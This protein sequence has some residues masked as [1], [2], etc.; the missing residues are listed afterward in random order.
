MVS[1]KVEEGFPVSANEN[2]FLRVNKIGLRIA[3][4]IKDLKYPYSFSVLKVEDAN[5]FALPGG[6][7]YVTTGLLELG[8]EDS[9]LAFVLA[10]EIAHNECDHIFKIK[11]KANLL[12]AIMM[13]IEI[14]AMSQTSSSKDARQ[15]QAEAAARSLAYSLSGAMVVSGYSREFEREADYWGK[16]YLAKAGYDI[17]GAKTALDKIDIM[18]QQR[19]D[20]FSSLLMTHPYILERVEEAE[21][22]SITF[23]KDILI[24]SKI[25][26]AGNFIQSYLLK[27]ASVY[28]SKEKKNVSFLLYRNTYFLYPDGNRADEAL[29]QLIKNKEELERKKAKFLVNWNFLI[30]HYEI[31]LEKY[32]DTF[33]K[34]EVTSRL[35]SLKEERNEVYKWY[36]ENIGKDMKTD[37]YF[38]F[39]AFFPESPLVP[40]A[41]Y[42]L[43]KEYISSKD[44]DKALNQLITLSEDEQWKEKAKEEIIPIIDKSTD[45]VLLGKLL[46]MDFSP[47]SESPTIHYGDE[48]LSGVGIPTSERASEPIIKDKINARLKETI[49]K[50]KDLD[51]LEVRTKGAAVA[52]GDLPLTGLAQLDKFS[53]EFPQSEHNEMVARRKGKLAEELYMEARAQSLSGNWS[54]TVRIYR[55]ILKYAPDS[56]SA[57]QIRQE[58]DRL[59]KIRKAEAT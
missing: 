11:S 5:A 18:K 50:V 26:K 35:E 59:E 38:N 14:F 4:Q 44:Y 30:M 55:Q 39:I 20:L 19:P 32:P 37:Y 49:P 9:E 56:P 45:I 41:R 47:M 21:S 1:S 33:L 22:P 23:P 13:G 10:H 31:L 54:K 12:S 36:A 3:S 8:L 48:G 16:I 25:R 34:S 7:V 53:K 52:S 28:E 6:F 58:F 40:R 46:D 29:Y 43:A 15:V 2:E 27:E 42:F 24:E 51:P 17:S 57:E